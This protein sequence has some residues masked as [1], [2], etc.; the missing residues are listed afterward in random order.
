MIILEGPNLPLRAE[1]A[2]KLKEYLQGKDASQPE[3]LLRTDLG[4]LVHFVHQDLRYRV[5]DGWPVDHLSAA[6]RHMLG[7]ALLPEA[8]IVV[9]CDG[10]HATVRDLSTTT[11]RLFINNG[12]CSGFS[13]G[14]AMNQE[15]ITTTILQAHV[16]LLTQL[17]EFDRFF[18]GTWWEGSVMLVGEGNQFITREVRRKAFTS[19]TGCSLFLHEALLRN[20]G[21]RYYLSNA[22]KTGRPAYD[23]LALQREIELV[24][25]VKIVALGTEAAAML[26][27]QRVEFTRTFHPQYWKRFRNQHLDELVEILKP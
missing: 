8:L 18:A 9:H 21:A 11:Q 23:R 13:V 5:Q 10:S 27:T 17:R 20:R 4:Y 16:T 19:A 25:P 1:L 3:E 2:T 12:F 15:W 6:A 22:Q 26:A 7:C 14:A 24:K